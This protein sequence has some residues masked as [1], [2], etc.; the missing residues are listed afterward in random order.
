MSFKGS[1][2]KARV[3]NVT[4]RDKVIDLFLSWST[5]RYDEFVDHVA[6]VTVFKP[7]D[8]PRLKARDL[9]NIGQVS[10]EVNEPENWKRVKVGE[11]ATED[12][13]NVRFFNI[14]AFGDQIEVV[15]QAD[16]TSAPKKKRLPVTDHD[17]DDLPF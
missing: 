3:L 16:P 15:T 8:A 6:N 1:I 12:S 17:V 11:K 7:A 10:V 4:K 5:R 14:L 2:T 9:I 13:P